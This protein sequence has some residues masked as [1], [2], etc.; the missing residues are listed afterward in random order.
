MTTGRINQVWTEQI[1]ANKEINELLPFSDSYVK[2][3]PRDDNF[4]SE[5]QCSIKSEIAPPR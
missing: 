5:D 4:V 3:T 1:S 2:T